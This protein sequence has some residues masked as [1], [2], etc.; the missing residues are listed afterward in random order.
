MEREQL[1]LTPNLL[2]VMRGGA[3]HA[4]A[5]GANAIAPA[6]LLLALL[7]DPA[8]GAALTAV[9]PVETLRAA[10]ARDNGVVDDTLAF[11]TRDGACTLYLN[12][13]AYH[14]FIEGGRRASD[15][16]LPKDLVIGFTAQALKDQEILALLGGDPQ[17]VAEAL[18][19]A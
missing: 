10:A 14:L 2:A 6:H 7:D 8:L 18:I 13:A 12:R 9:V 4:L 11:R 3:A 16:Y 17:R 15:V 19:E 1:R 5:Y